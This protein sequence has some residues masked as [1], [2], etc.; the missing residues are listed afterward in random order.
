V[1]ISIILLINYFKKLFGTKNQN[2]DSWLRQNIISICE[3]M[4]Y[5]WDIGLKSRYY[6]EQGLKQNPNAVKEF[7]ELINTENDPKIQQ[8][9]MYLLREIK[10]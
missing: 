8:V 9:A 1:K 7:Q 5:D 10:K 3:D 2:R 4:E 6:L